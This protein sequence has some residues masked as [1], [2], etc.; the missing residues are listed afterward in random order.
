MKS[1]SVI[2]YSDGCCVM[3]SFNSDLKLTFYLRAEWTEFEESSHLR[4]LVYGRGVEHS[5]L[6]S[7]TTN[8]YRYERPRESQ[9]IISV[10]IQT[11]FYWLLLKRE[12]SARNKALLDVCTLLNSDFCCKCEMWPR[13]DNHQFWWFF[14]KFFYI[15]NKLWHFFES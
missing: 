3:F 15:T 6:F 13:S 8:N 2:K 11:R 9:R 5:K 7:E 10:S 12:L 4:Y 14:D 1:S